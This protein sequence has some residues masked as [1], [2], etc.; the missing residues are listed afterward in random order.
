MVAGKVLCVH[1]GSPP[2][3]PP[4]PFPAHLLSAK[5]LAG[6]LL[7]QAL[8]CVEPKHILE[9]SMPGVPPPSLTAPPESLMRF[10]FL[11]PSLIG[12]PL[13]STLASPLGVLIHF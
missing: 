7:P 2:S 13:G 10:F 5:E 3:L 4:C 12:V 6:E 11:F 9:T 8:L 1:I